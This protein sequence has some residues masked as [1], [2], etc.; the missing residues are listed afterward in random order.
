MYPL[1]NG[2]R[3]SKQSGSPKPQARAR[4]NGAT[5]CQ[6]CNGDGFE[7]RCPLCSGTGFAT[8]R[9]DTVTSNAVQGKLDQESQRLGHEVRVGL[10]QLIELRSNPVV[11]RKATVGWISQVTQAREAL[12]K[13]FNEVTFLS[14]VGRIEKL[15]ALTKKVQ[16]YLQEAT[17]VL[18]KDEPS[19]LNSLHRST[20]KFNRESLFAAP[21]DALPPV[22]IGRMRFGMDNHV[23]A[24]HMS[25]LKK[26]T[27]H[28]I[29]WLPRMPDLLI[30]HSLD[31]CDVVVRGVSY[32]ARLINDSLVE[33]VHPISG[34]RTRSDRPFPTPQPPKAKRTSK[35]RKEK[36]KPN[37]PT[38]EKSAVSASKK[39][40]HGRVKHKPVSPGDTPSTRVAPTDMGD[41]R[42][43]PRGRDEDG[44]SGT[45]VFREY[46]SG[47]FGSYPS[48]DDYE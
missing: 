33:L 37:S 42:L 7:G 26:R 3:K 31:E 38:P 22:M 11:V 12:Q 9:S 45:H 47:Q 36:I 24:A 29:A 27:H 44:T 4:S 23:I 6:R 18:Q 39:K 48:H 34:Q 28:L 5:I 41:S 19:L 1:A 16:A 15:R 10:D 25:S 30:W 35:Q 40:F 43:P 46:G 8:L 21:P 32:P 2:R 20:H 13:E 14:D 17:K